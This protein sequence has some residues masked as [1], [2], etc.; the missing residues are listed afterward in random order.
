VSEAAPTYREAEKPRGSLPLLPLP[1]HHITQAS[2]AQTS[3]GARAMTGAD[4]K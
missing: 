4:G 2:S 1:G 3:K